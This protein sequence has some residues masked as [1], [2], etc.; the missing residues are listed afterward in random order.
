MLDMEVAFLQTAATPGIGRECDDR[1]VSI[2]QFTITKQLKA[3]LLG[4]ESP[5]RPRLKCYPYL[6]T[7]WL[8]IGRR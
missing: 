3:A 4:V 7:L 5:T 8:P 2:S 6:I 1:S